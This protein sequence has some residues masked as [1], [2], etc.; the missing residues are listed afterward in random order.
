MSKEKKLIL[1]FQGTISIEDFCPSTIYWNIFRAKRKA[2]LKLFQKVFYKQ[3]KTLLVVANS[4]L[5]DMVF[6]S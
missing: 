3:F 5:A 1:S 4:T 2:F 6:L